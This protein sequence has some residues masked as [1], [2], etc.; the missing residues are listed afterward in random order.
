ML[1]CGLAEVVEDAV[2]VGVAGGRVGD[3]SHG[4]V[5]CERLVAGFIGNFFEG[6]GKVG[7]P[8]CEF[9]VGE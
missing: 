1:F 8:V 6:F 7:V 5:G 4:H 2:E 3:V 9:G